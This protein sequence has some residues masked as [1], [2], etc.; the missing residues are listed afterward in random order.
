MPEPRSDR[1]VRRT[2]RVLRDAL[3]ALT[4]ERGWDAVSVLDVCEHADIGRSTFYAHFADKEDLL[5]SA[6]DDLHEHMAARRT[7]E[8]FGFAE[9]LLAHAAENED[10]YRAV[11]GRESG[12]QMV[13]RFRDVLSSIVEADLVS[14]DIADRE[15]AVRFIAGGFLELMASWL[16][17]PTRREHGEVATAFRRLAHACVAR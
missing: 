6:F 10:L 12:Q 2:R 3:V 13:W 4:L 16:D 14:L 17:A 11:A 7:V 8:P 9:A 5:L 15:I 1:R